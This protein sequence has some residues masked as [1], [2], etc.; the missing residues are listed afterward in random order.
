MMTRR[1]CLAAALVVPMVA[2]R[3]DHPEIRAAIRQF[4]AVRH[5]DDEADEDEAERLYDHL[6]NLLAE[7]GFA[8]VVVGGVHYGSRRLVAEQRDWSDRYGADV[9]RAALIL[10]LDAQNGGVR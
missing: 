1:S 10:N 3:D 8:A 7:K 4:E 9:F 6:S 5:G 2:P